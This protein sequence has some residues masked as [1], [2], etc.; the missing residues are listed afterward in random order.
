[1]RSSAAKWGSLGSNWQKK[2]EGCLGGEG[3]GFACA[4]ACMGEN[5]GEW[6]EQKTNKKDKIPVL[7]VALHA[8]WGD[9]GGGDLAIVPHVGDGPW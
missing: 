1:M 9:G 5:I 4:K 6:I 7:G 3:Q 2:E 8:G